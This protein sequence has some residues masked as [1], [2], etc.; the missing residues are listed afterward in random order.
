VGVFKYNQMIK[1]N[2]PLVHLILFLLT[3]NIF[4][5]RNLNIE[6]SPNFRTLSGITNNEGKK[7]KE[8]IVYRSGNFS[9]LSD[10]DIKIFNSLNINTIVDFRNDDEINKDPDFIP[11]GQKIVTKRAVIGSINPKGMSRFMQVLMNPKF[12][13]EDVDSLMIDANKNF[14][15][16]VR[17]FKP[18]FEAL[19]EENSVVLFHCSAGK[20][21]TGLASS[22]LLHIL[23]M[24]K[25][26]IF[27]DYLKSNEA[28]SKINF[29][30]YNQIGVPAERMALLMGVKASYLESAWNSITKKY[31]SIDNMLLIEFGIDAKT[32]QRI[33]DKYLTK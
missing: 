7:I 30:K 6:N 18:F 16:S 1:K 8:A 5:Q 14:V 2:N 26:T 9:K 12:K 3:F 33:K 32:K 11:Q 13:K 22:L 24:S 15:E 4:A 31:G 19:S 10:S 17:D 28:V 21:R 20:D 25:E 23:D 27:E 29:E